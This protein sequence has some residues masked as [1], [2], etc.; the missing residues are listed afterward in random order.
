[1]PGVCLG[2]CGRPGGTRRGTCNCQTCEAADAVGQRGPLEQDPEKWAPVFPRDK[3][4]AFA[5]RSCS[6]KKIERND[7]FE[8][9][10]SRSR[11][12]QTTIAHSR[13]PGSRPPVVN[14]V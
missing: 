7:G 6:N 8:E 5:R 1:M 11:P 9:K 13:E 3:R 12:K 14:P 4:E 10:S 2:R